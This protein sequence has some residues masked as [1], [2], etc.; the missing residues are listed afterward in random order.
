MAERA[1]TGNREFVRE[2]RLYPAA[3]PR[4]KRS[5]ATSNLRKFLVVVAW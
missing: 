2:Q 5:R 1:A 3:E 4:R